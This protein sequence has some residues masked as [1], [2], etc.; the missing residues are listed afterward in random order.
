MPRWT[1]ADETALPSQEE[2]GLANQAINELTLE[3]E[4]VT[5]AVDASKLQNLDWGPYQQTREQTVALMKEI[6]VLQAWIAPIRKLPVEILSQIFVSVAQIAPLGPVRITEV[7]RLW[8]Q[9]VIST[10]RAWV[11]IYLAR[12]NI[13]KDPKQYFSTFM[14][15]SEP[16]LLHLF[17]PKEEYNDPEDP[18][19]RPLEELIKAQSHR[20]QCLTIP[21]AESQLQRP[22]TTSFPHV[23]HLYVTIHYSCPFSISAALFPSLRYLDCS[24]ASWLTISAKIEFPPLQYLSFMLDSGSLWIAILQRC[25]TTLKGLKVIGRFLE[26]EP[27][28]KA[29][30]VFPLLE[31]LEYSDYTDLDTGDELG[32][33]PIEAI[34]PRLISYANYVDQIDGNSFP[35]M[36]TDVKYVTHLNT[37]D[38]SQLASYTSLHFLQIIAFHTTFERVFTMLEELGDDPK[39]LPALEKIHV[40]QS[41]E[42]GPLE[43]ATTIVF[44]IEE[45]ILHL[46]PNVD[47]TISDGLNPMPL[48]FEELEVCLCMSRF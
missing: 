9:A 20:I 25:S 24:G 15:R 32:E 2:I 10:P 43:L 48:G 38:V 29:R 35:T 46:W 31:H 22:I 30:I 36:H 26:C 19:Q 47:L 40:S 8:H 41:S 42:E 13:Y 16:Y 3:L 37:D 5:D 34:T 6:Q 14:K 12:K 1:P 7:C 39:V 23:D 27:A 11:H 18:S 44:M 45:K 4:R 21:N 17:L 33:W 28:P